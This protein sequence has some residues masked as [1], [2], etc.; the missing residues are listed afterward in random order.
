ME[1]LTPLAAKDIKQ[2]KTKKG[3]DET[4]FFIIEGTKFVE[5]IPLQ[6]QVL[7]YAV[8]QSYSDCYDISFF[9][10]R[11]PCTILRD[12]IFNGLADTVSPQGILAVCKKHEFSFADLLGNEPKFILLGENLNDPGNI[13]TLVRTAV[14]AGACG[15]ILTHGS[16]DIYSPKVLRA[17]AGAVMRIPFLVEAHLED[18]A[19][20]LKKHNIPIYAAHPH[21]GKSPYNLNLSTNACIL[22]G[23]E[24]HGLSDKALELAN[25]TVTLPMVNSTESLNASVAGSV[26]M[27]EVLRQ[28]QAALQ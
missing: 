22:I 11:A 3:R 20:M 18:V 25:E 10:N 23:N 5:E 15:V 9:E 28:R 8:S 2:L 7:Q 17:S 16:S 21:G 19:V 13:G 26:L 24:S 27:Y 12:S 1:E 6:W 4:G 14:A